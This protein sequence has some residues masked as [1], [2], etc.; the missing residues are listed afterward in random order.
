[1]TKKFKSGLKRSS[2]NC[3]QFL[4]HCFI[5]CDATAQLGPRLK[6]LNHTQLDTHTHPVGLVR[7]SEQLVAEVAIHRTNTT[8]IHTLSGI[9]TLDPSNQ[10][11]VDLQLRHRGHRDRQCKLLYRDLSTETDENQTT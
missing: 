6:F 9:R 5:F 11:A 3:G 1:M 2:N 10:A 4:G 8:N 7:T